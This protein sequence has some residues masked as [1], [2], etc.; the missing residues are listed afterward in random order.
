MQQHIHLAESH[1]VII[2]VGQ[3][4]WKSNEL[5]KYVMI[6]SGIRIQL[7]SHMSFRLMIRH[8]KVRPHYNRQTRGETLA[9]LIPRKRVFCVVVVGGFLDA[10]F[11]I[12][13][14]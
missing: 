6:N 2:P 11:K 13:S 9:S 12:V 7:I 10:D 1:V 8:S 3:H 5:I 14:I 4:V